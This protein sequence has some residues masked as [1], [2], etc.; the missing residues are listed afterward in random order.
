MATCISVITDIS[1]CGYRCVGTVYTMLCRHAANRT[2]G[3]EPWLPELKLDFRDVKGQLV[4]FQ[5]GV[6]LVYARVPSI[7]KLRIQLV[8][9]LVSVAS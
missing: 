1:D 2:W 7:P 9:I 5:I 6:V 3:Y 8:I 4:T